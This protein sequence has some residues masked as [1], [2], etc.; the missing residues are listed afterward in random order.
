MSEDP[1]L[2]PTEAAFKRDPLVALLDVARLLR[3]RADQRAREHGLTRAQWVILARLG[4]NPGMTQNELA[5]LAEV[6]PITVARLIDRLEKRGFVER[7]PDPMDRRVW[8]LHLLPAAQP[9]LKILAKAKEE[10]TAMLVSGISA[11]A[12]RTTIDCLLEMKAN[13][14]AETW[15]RPEKK[16]DV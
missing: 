16:R 14:A 3:T 6:E 9:M 12:L 1:F 11:D 8:R 15:C 13:M 2:S 10:C 5:V 7:R 4:H